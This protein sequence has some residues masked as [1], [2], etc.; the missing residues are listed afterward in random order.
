MGIYS[1]P[2]YFGALN[3]IESDIE[4]S[5]HV[6]GN[7]QTGFSASKLITLPNGEPSDDE[8]KNIEQRFTKRFSGSDGKKFILSFVTDPQRKPIIDDLGASDITKEDFQ[9]VDELIQTNIF[10]L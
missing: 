8:K 2:T 5:K 3:Y 1:L 4:I 7:A 10:R 9:K 6:L